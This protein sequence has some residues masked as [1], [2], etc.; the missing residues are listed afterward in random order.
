[1]SRYDL[2]VIGAGPA[3]MAAAIYGI[4]ANLKVLLLEKLAPGGQLINTNEIENYPGSGKIN[5]SELAF[6]MF[7][8]VQ[9]LGVEFD[10]RT[11]TKVESLKNIKKVYTE[12]DEDVI[13]TL[14]LITATGTRPRTLSIPGEEEYKESA[15]SWC[16]ICDGA[17]YRDKDV[18]IVGGG[19]SA[20]DEGTYLATIVKSLTIITDFDLTA[21][22]VSSDYLRSLPNVTV[23]PYKRV[24]EFIGEADKFRGV[25]FADKETGENEQIVNCDGV[26][27]YIGS[28]PST[29]FLQSINILENDGFIETNERMATKI[30]G[31]FAA[32]DCINKHLRQVV[33]A[34]SDG[35]IAAQEV[36]SYIKELKRQ[37]NIIQGGIDMIKEL[38]KE[39]F[40]NDLSTGAVLV[41]FY[42]KNCGPCKMLDFILK[43]IDEEFD[44][45]IK[46]IK[47]DFEENPGLIDEHNVE[48]YPTLIMFKDGK[49]VSRKSGLQQKPVIIKM[50][51]EAL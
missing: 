4:R 2:V 1:M 40:I 29:E 26:F 46:M 31:I 15:I 44:G 51:E 36:C 18:V 39:E 9:K 32:G 42:S 38:V 5:G 43:D 19:N 10:Y 24:V 50:I 22:P 49:E 14:T 11:V 6:K 48:G 35:A 23:Y 28:I 21:D 25:K 33:T 13:E 7:Q 12:E 27:E 3:G 20:V 16:A 8:H 37:R 45:N 47:V 41:D 30:P 17:K 34:T